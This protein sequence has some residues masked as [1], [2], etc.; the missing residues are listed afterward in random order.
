MGQEGHMSRLYGQVVRVT[1][2]AGREP[3]AFTWHGTQYRVA[4]VLASWHLVDRWWLASAQEAARAS[5]KG[6]QDA[7]YRA[8]SDREYYRVRCAD[9]QVFDLY[10]DA[11]TGVWV[12]DRAHD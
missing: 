12:L 10:Y 7:R 9:H 4:E 6:V 5:G 3:T 2:A 11:A 8:A 1:C